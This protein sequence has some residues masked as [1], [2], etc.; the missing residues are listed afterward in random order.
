MGTQLLPKFRIIDES[1]G[2][3]AFNANTIVDEIHNTLYN[4]LDTLKE[5]NPMKDSKFLDFY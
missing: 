2:Q 5:N 1:E 4:D 3:K